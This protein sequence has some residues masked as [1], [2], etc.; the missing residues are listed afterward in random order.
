MRG[1]KPSDQTAE[2]GDTEQQRRRDGIPIE[3]D[4][5]ERIAAVAERFGLA[6]LITAAGDDLQRAVNPS[7]EVGA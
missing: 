5:W 7:R 1:G 4:T 2:L 3:D 6:S